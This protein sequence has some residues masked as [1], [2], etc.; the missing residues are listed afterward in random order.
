MIPYLNETSKEMMKTTRPR[1]RHCPPFPFFIF[2]LALFACSDPDPAQIGTI[3]FTSNADCSFRLFDGSGR[4]CAH[5][6]YCLGQSPAVVRMKSTGVFIIHAE[7][8]GKEIKKPITY[9]SGN[10]EYFIEF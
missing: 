9:L 6:V 5:D 3:A 10:L 2:A 7:S 1:R 4:Q 8:A